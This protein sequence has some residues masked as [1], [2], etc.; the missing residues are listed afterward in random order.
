MLRVERSERAG[1][2]SDD[3]RRQIAG[4][5]RVVVSRGRVE[6]VLPRRLLVLA[7]DTQALTC[8]ANRESRRVQPTKRRRQV[9]RDRVQACSLRPTSHKRY[10]TLVF[11][12]TNFLVC[13]E[14]AAQAGA[15]GGA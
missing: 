7:P 15:R 10:L 9:G 11:A 2:V 14:T 4:I 1:T 6:L 13:G 3:D 5:A 12:F 8:P